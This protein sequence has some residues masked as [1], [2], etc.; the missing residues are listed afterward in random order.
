MFEIKSEKKIRNKK[1]NKTT[2]YEINL[3]E[4]QCYDNILQKEILKKNRINFCQKT[5]QKFSTELELQKKT[6]VEL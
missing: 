2:Q 5:L 1:L 4:T 3:S 6:E